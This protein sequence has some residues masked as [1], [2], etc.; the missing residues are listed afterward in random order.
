MISSRP[1]EFPNLRA[2]LMG[3]SLASAPTIAE[4]NFARTS[5]SNEA[6]G[7]VGFWGNPIKI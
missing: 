6:A 1:D 7:K 5:G 3:P 4:K 2:S